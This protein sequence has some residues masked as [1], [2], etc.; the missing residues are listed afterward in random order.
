MGTHAN[1]LP[2][3]SMSILT[4][5]NTA[6]GAGVPRM[7]ILASMV[8]D[9]FTATDM[10][11]TSASGAVQLPPEAIA[12]IR[13]PAAT[14]DRRQNQTRRDGN[15]MR[16]P[17]IIE[18]YADDADK[19]IHIYE[20]IA[21]E[22]PFLGSKNTFLRGVS[23]TSYKLIPSIARPGN[24]RILQYEDEAIREALKQFPETILGTDK[25]AI[26]DTITECLNQNKSK[27]PHGLAW[28]SENAA[29]EEEILRNH[30]LRFST[31]I[32]ESEPVTLFDLAILQHYGFPTRLL[33]IT[34]DL[35][36]ATFF[37][38]QDCYEKSST[39]GLVYVFD[40]SLT[41][42]LKR[43][44]STQ[45]YHDFIREPSPFAFR[46]TCP[47]FRD[48][49]QSGDFIFV[50]DNQSATTTDRHTLVELEEKGLVAAKIVVDGA[51][52]RKIMR[53]FNACPHAAA[54][55][56]TIYAD[57]VE[58]CFKAVAQAFRVGEK[59]W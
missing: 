4:M 12:S 56:K 22:D 6:S 14:N 35:S 37:A 31:K 7:A 8:R 13:Q 43:I 24:E 29:I 30:S 32:V 2:T 11:P 27:T 5:K 10:V 41:S 47:F 52:K 54:N 50:P 57:G 38:C 18:Y 42:S 49:C 59:I 36:V 16:K 40:K 23:D 1:T 15:H 33:D 28:V 19:L 39:N 21:K 25:A 17:S 46:L 53:E 55:F 58:T 45:S 51:A 34:T 48:E 3:I 9:I 20:A 44:N 26:A